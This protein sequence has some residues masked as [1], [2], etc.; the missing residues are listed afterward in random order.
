MLADSWARLD[1]QT[2][3]IDRV[4]DGRKVSSQGTG[5]FQ[6]SACITSAICPTGQ[7]KSVAKPRV[8][9]WEK[10]SHTAKKCADRDGSNLWPFCDLL[11][12][13]ILAKDI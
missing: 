3:L 13:A 4:E 8:R 12:S 5:A 9:Q 10:Q 7:C 11:H 6:A 1:G 2:E